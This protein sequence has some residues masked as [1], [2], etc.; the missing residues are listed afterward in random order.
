MMYTSSRVETSHTLNNYYYANIK[1]IPDESNGQE[2]Y[3]WSIECT[4]IYSC[5]K[6][7]RTCRIDK[8]WC[9][10]V[11]ELKLRTHK[12]NIMTQTTKVV[13]TKTMVRK[14]IYDQLKALLKLLLQK[15]HE[16]VE[17]IYFVVCKFQ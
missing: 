2:A 13:A 9:I 11:P 5:E 10:N 14:V 12:L 7:S 3:L 8:V 16:L 4:T 15:C 6:I 1:S 17:S